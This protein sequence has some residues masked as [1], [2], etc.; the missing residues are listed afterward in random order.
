MN[1]LK[2][3][4]LLGLTRAASTL[5]NIIPELQAKDFEIGLETDMEADA[6]IASVEEYL[7]KLQ[8]T[9]QYVR[10]CLRRIKKL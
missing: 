9:I 8:D 1:S 2:N 3:E 6:T 4:A 10:D 7:R 5:I